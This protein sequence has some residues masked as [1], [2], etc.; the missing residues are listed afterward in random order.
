M[1]PQKSRH[2]PARNPRSRVHDDRRVHAK[3]FVAI[4]HPKF[5]GAVG[6]VM[7]S[8]LAERKFPISELVVRERSAGS[9][10]DFRG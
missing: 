6:E 9:H 10:I 2:V 5:T 3:H 8:I 4:F 7:L 1:D